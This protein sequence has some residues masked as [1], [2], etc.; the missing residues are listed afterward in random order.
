[1]LIVEQT[2][3]T[4]RTDQSQKFDDYGKQ[5]ADAHKTQDFKDFEKLIINQHYTGLSRGYAQPLLGHLAF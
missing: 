4:K 3:N 5:E 2:E 1:M